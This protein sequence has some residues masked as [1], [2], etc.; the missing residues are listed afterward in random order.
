MRI[1]PSGTFFWRLRSDRGRGWR[2]GQVCHGDQKRDYR[3]FG[4]VVKN[5]GSGSFLHRTAI[6]ARMARRSRNW[7]A[8]ICFQQLPGVE[9]QG[10]P[11]FLKG[12]AGEPD[13]VLP[14]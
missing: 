8:G 14:G 2:Q 10:T 4:G 1:R 12:D 6:R 7:S 5:K 13:T 3:Y 9:N 11:A